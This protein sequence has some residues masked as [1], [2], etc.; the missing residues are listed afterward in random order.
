VEEVVNKGE[1]EK[2]MLNKN[3]TTLKYIHYTLI[4]VLEGIVRVH[5]L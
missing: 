1:D 4:N 3:I 5:T 2:I